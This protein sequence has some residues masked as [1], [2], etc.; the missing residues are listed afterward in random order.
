MVFER[1]IFI[2]ISVSERYYKKITSA[3]CR[4]KFASLAHQ[5]RTD[6]D[7]KK[8]LENEIME[9]W[10]TFRDLEENVYP[11]DESV[12]RIEDMII[13]FSLL[14]EEYFK[15]E[16][17]FIMCRVLVDLKKVARETFDQRLKAIMR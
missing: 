14:L 17:I 13:C 1:D 4:S 9:V 12:F 5:F 8:K 10:F 7:A 3:E 6:K 15:K 16:E 11:Y 2:D